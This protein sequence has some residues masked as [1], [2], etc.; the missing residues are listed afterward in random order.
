MKQ[1]KFIKIVKFLWIVIFILFAIAI[2]TQI[3]N[4]Q[5]YG[6]LYIASLSIFVITW[7]LSI[8]AASKDKEHLKNNRI[9]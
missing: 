2:T 3:F 7:I 5:L 4:I 6:M 1:T 8:I 9:S